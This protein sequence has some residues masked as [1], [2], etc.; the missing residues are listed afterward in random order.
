MGGGKCSS[1]LSPR[2]PVPRLRP[3]ARLLALSLNLPYLDHHAAPHRYSA[4]PATLTTHPL[5]PPQALLSSPLGPTIFSPSSR[6]VTKE[7]HFFDWRPFIASCPFGDYLKSL[8]PAA[9]RLSMDATPDYLADPVT[10]ANIGSLMPQARMIVLVRDPSE[11]MMGEYAS[12]G[13]GG[14][15]PTPDYLADPV[16]AANIGSLMP[17]ARMVVL[18]RDP[19]E[20]KEGGMPWGRG[21][22][23]AAGDA[24]THPL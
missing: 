9:G 24:H 20:H 14:Y 21:G 13:K 8:R 23:R 22:G 16:T 2:P 10:A 11:F 4:A 5:L 15:A 3:P 12:G 7:L 19:S 17:E 6:R 18:V 1:P